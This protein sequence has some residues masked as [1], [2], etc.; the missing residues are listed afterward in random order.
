MRCPLSTSNIDT[1]TPQATRLGFLPLLEFKNQHYSIAP[2]YYHLNLVA[3]SQLPSTPAP[4][5][6]L[7]RSKGRPPRHPAVSS[8]V[9]FSPSLHAAVLGALTISAGAAYA[10]KAVPRSSRR[11]QAASESRIKQR[12]QSQEHSS[13]SII[14]THLNYVNPLNLAKICKPSQ[15]F[16]F[17]AS[18]IST[19]CTFPCTT[20]QVPSWIT[21]KDPAPAHTCPSPSEQVPCS[22]TLS[23]TRGL[24]RHW[25]HDT[26][27]DQ[28]DASSTTGQHRGSRDAQR[29]RSVGAHDPQA[30]GSSGFPPLS[31]TPCL[32]VR[33]AFHLAL[34]S[35]TAP[36]R[37]AQRK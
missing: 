21:R 23:G 14:T 25:V 36:A 32:R 17:L 24:G 20:P 28:T 19:R 1:G 27:L 3:F 15:A 33:G 18:D 35:S 30:R 12:A 4:E 9:H 13:L 31:R 2:V 16:N 26:I 5:P 29:G 8:S 37:F 7:P 10:P 6:L 34:A 11:Y 22:R